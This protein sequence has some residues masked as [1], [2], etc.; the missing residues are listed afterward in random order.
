MAPHRITARRDLL[1]VLLLL[2][3]LGAS[4]AQRH[5]ITAF[6]EGHGIPRLQLY[7]VTYNEAAT[8]NVSVLDPSFH[9]SV[10]IGRDSSSIVSLDIQ[11]MIYGTGISS[12]VVSITSDADISLITFLTDNYSA[13]AV[14]VLPVEDL[15]TE[16]F[17]FT[18]DS[19]YEN[20]FT[21]ANGSLTYN[22]VVY[23]HGSSFSFHLG[24]QQVIQLQS[25]TD[26]TGTRV[27]ATLPVAVFSGNKCFSG[28]NTA[29]DV[30]LEQ[31]HPVRNWGTV[32]PVFPLATH[33]KDIIDMMAANPDTVVS[34]TTSQQNTQY[35]LQPG[36]HVQLTLDRPAIVNSSEPV[37]ISYLFQEQ[38]L[39]LY[40]PFLTSIP[41]IPK[42]R[43][44]NKFITQ[45]FY[46]N[47]LL[48]LS[49]A[50]SPS[51]FYLDHQPLSNFLLNSSEINGFQAWEVSLGK[52]DGQHEI[53]HSSSAFTIYV[54][55]LGQFVSYGYSMGQETTHPG[56][57]ITNPTEESVSL[58]SPTEEPDS[59]QELH[60]FS[61]GA[62]FHL[63]LRSVSEAKLNASNIH[64]QD[65]QCCKR[66]TQS[67][68][69]FH[70]TDVGP[71][72]MCPLDSTLQNQLVPDQRMKRYSFHVFKFNP[73]QEVYLSCNV[74]ICHN[75]T[76][77]NRC[78][79]GCITHRYRR[80]VPNAQL[81]SARL[82]Q[83]PIVLKSG[84]QLPN[85]RAG[86]SVS[87]VVLVAV[88]VAMACLSVMGLMIQRRYY[89][90]PED[91]QQLLMS[92]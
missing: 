24:Y 49:Q 11:Y 73:F 41:P 44:Y 50:A 89:R 64:L 29:C 31:M 78:T 76:A 5:F 20:Q 52:I 75:Q 62:K 15:D 90:R 51:D 86:G 92:Y 79:Q 9:Q 53:Y 13:D 45:S 46:E 25:S 40:D 21:V 59:H 80:D 1:I 14:S 38:I 60:C 19:G 55:G 42:T 34:V 61:D 66:G 68:L 28:I 56:P 77:P 35:S 33:S 12:K 36:S 4:Q 81:G 58:T 65:P 83:G 8:V 48:F 67:S 85:G 26:L 88:I 10:S 70:S 7:L 37:M 17:I 30:L 72:F 27:V 91:A 39:G 6:M 84:A 3:L 32:F 43:K 47:V 69:K 87:S 54:Y 82:S 57:S 23:G 18:Q 16:Y 74:I 63:P 2:G 71:M 22:G